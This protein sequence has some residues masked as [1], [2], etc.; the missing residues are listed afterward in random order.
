MRMAS[1][2]GKMK[3]VLVHIEFEYLQNKPRWQFNINVWG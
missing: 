2:G 1:L 3:T